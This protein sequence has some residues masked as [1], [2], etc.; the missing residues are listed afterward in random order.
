MYKTMFT[1]IAGMYDDKIQHT[2]CGQLKFI[3]SDIFLIFLKENFRKWCIYSVHHAHTFVVALINLMK[4]T[5]RQE[6]V[7]ESKKIS[8]TNGFNLCQTGVFG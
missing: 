5:T 7:I 2:F 3:L 6:Q 8:T 1:Y 4:Y